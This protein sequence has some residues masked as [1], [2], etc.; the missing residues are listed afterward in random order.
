VSSSPASR[1]YRSDR[2]AQQAA[3]TRAD[4]IAAATELFAERGWAATTVAAV[5]ARAGVAVDTV[6]AG[7]RSKAGLLAAAKDVAL[8]GDEA[9]IP[10]L[11][12]PE[13][14]ALGRGSRRERLRIAAR[15]SA[16]AN[17][18]TAPL[19]AAFREAAATDQ[20]LAAS[21]L[22]REALRHERMVAGFERILERPPDPDVVDAIWVLLGW[23]TYTKLTRERG[24]TAEQYEAWTLRMLERLT[25]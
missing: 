21:L 5:A 15:V 8:F 3:Q 14:E 20:S 18:R 10:P 9:S 2:R 23:E 7:F 11:E 13:L 4:I 25:A 24:W 6:Y 1:N 19:N 17:A 22:E 16:A 12:R